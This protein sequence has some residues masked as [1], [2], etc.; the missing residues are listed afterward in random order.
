M[1]RKIRFVMTAAL[2][3]MC[4][5]VSAQ[6]VPAMEG[7]P[8]KGSKSISVSGSL[9][10]SS[11]FVYGALGY[12]LSDSFEIAGIG[13]LNI[14]DDGSGSTT[15]SGMVGG[16]MKQ[17]FRKRG[18]TVPYISLLAL[19]PVG[20][21][22]GGGTLFGSSVGL[23][24]FMRPQQSF[25]LELQSMWSSESDGEADQTVNFGLRYFIP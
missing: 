23:D 15:T 13:M 12:F 7:G 5:V 14:M 19:S 21:N 11:G 2:A 25:F 20:D 9:Q 17:H 22:S 6:G 8:Q 4:V 3:A 18:T 1:T 10:E 24:F 16:T